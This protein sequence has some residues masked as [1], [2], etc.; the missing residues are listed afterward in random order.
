M[1]SR[2]AG[3]KRE[4]CGV[5]S[6]TNKFQLRFEFYHFRFSSLKLDGETRFRQRAGKPRLLFEMACNFTNL[7]DLKWL[8]FCLLQPVSLSFSMVNG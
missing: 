8:L 7:Y 1:G 3:K 2:L 5:V 4:R 6:Y